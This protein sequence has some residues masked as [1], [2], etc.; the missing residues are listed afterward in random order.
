MNFIS[1]GFIVFVIIV[2]VVYWFLNFKSRKAQNLILLAASYV[3]YGMLDLKFLAILLSISLLSYAYGLY[4]YKNNHKKKRTVFRLTILLTTSSLAYFKYYNFFITEITKFL[5]ALGINSG[6]TT[7]SIILPIGISFYT[8]QALGYIIDVYY[9]RI[10]PELNI[11]DFLLFISFFPQLFAGPIGKA[12]DLIPQ[13]KE[14]RIFE[15]NKG[16][17]GLKLILYG[18]FKKIVIADQIGIAVDRIFGDYTNYSASTLILGAIFYSIQIYADFSGYTDIARGTAKMFGIDLMVNFKY[19][20][21]SR[22]IIDFWRRWHI[23]LSNWLRDYLFLPLSFIFYRR[24]NKLNVDSKRKEYLVYAVS[25]LITWLLGGLWHGAST[26]FI[27]WGLMHGT[28]LV[29]WNNSKRIRTKFYKKHNINSNSNT[30]I[31]IQ[32]ILTFLLVTFFWVFFRAGDLNTAFGYIKGLLNSNIFS[33]PNNGF[34]IIFAL[35]I[36]L[37]EY[38]Q[39]NKEHPMQLDFIKWKSIRWGI[40]YA[41][42][43]LIL[44]FTGNQSSFIYFQF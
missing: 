15:Y 4:F 3:F 38:L 40:Y 26:A 21:F 2:F 10:K 29:I 32:T 36:I 5:T 9:E 1:T 28:S 44:N 20:Y 16:T 19:P 37:I 39:R 33:I 43:L 13:Y 14:L 42:L 6:L 25:I 31:G 22:D 34:Y 8:F 24:L 27:A 18:F 7:A 23:S 41:M 12:K 11:L 35:P 30:F 17:E